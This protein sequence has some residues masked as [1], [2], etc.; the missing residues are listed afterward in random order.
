[1]PG[2]TSNRWHYGKV[3]AE[4]CNGTRLPYI[5]N[6]VNVIVVSPG[7]APVAKEELLRVLVPGGFVCTKTGDGWVRLVK[8]RPRPIDE[9][10]HYLHDASNNA[11]AHD[12]KSARRGTCNGFAIRPG[13]G[14]TTT[15]PA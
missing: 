14:T 9:W 1:M 6:L 3:S 10:T 11:V 13:R 8:P 2:V 7:A 4:V 15:W 5:D 12:A